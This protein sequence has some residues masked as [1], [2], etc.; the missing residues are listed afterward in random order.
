ML[1]RLSGPANKV[2]APLS[3]PP[4]YSFLPQVRVLHKEEWR[5]DQGQDF[6]PMMVE[7]EPFCLLELFGSMENGAVSFGVT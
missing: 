5:L 6:L 1:T 7:R 3:P 2:L 4:L